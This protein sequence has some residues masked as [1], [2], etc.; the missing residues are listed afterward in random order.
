LL[1][2]EDFTM[3]SLYYGRRHGSVLDCLNGLKKKKEK[4]KGKKLRGH[5]PI[6]KVVAVVKSR[7]NPQVALMFH[8]ITDIYRVSK[9]FCNP[10][11]HP[12]V[13]S[14]KQSRDSDKGK[15]I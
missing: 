13:I 2:N 8:L 1:K 15:V 6:S 5:D 12:S 14:T 3:D 4:T 7:L 11:D 9:V 10:N